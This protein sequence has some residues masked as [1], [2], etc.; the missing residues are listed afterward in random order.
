M[1][2]K[3]SFKSEKKEKLS[4]RFKSEEKREHFC[5]LLQIGRKRETFL[6]SVFYSEK[7]FV[8]K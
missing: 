8:C 1:S 2:I 6:F 7:I 4:F 3:I 5:F